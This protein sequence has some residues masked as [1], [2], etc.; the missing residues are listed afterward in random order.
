VIWHFFSLYGMW[1]RQGTDLA[2]RT[3]TQR[4]AIELAPIR[5]H[6]SPYDDQQ[7]FPLAEAIDK[8]PL[9]EGV[10]L[11]GTSLGA[12][13]LAVICANVRR[14]VDGVFG[15][16]ASS[17]GARGYPLNANV[18]FAHIISSWNPIPLPFLGTYRWPLGT[19]NAASYKREWHNIAHPGDYNIQDQDKFIREM[20][21]IKA[22]TKE[23][24]K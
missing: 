17:Y 1:G 18:L 11:A 23:R 10:L 19:M 14:L 20:K 6:N 13:N 22:N 4:V 16:Q 9:S 7:A 15:F 3:F 5:I 8:I 21:T 2:L 12:N 24:A